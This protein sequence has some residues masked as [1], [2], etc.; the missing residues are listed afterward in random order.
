MVYDF[1]EDPYQV[2]YFL[3]PRVFSLEMIRHKVI[4]ENENF[5]SFGKSLEVKFPWV[6]G[7]FIMKSKSSLNVVEILLK[8]IDFKTIFSMSYDPLHVI[9]TRRQV[10]KSK[11]FE[12][13]EVEGWLKKQIGQ[14]I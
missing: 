1:E 3:T 11:P 12:H 7:P 5:I 14:I 9:S 10:N 8:G 2:P 4:V 6:V 13:Q